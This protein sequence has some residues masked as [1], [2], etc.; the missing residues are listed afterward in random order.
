MSRHNTPT[1]TGYSATHLA[2]A[3]GGMLGTYI[4]EDH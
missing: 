2:Q 3:A 4:Q 1:S